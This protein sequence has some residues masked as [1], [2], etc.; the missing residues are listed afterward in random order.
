MK[1]LISIGICAALL[2][3]GENPFTPS[4]DDP[5]ADQHC[6]I[7]WPRNKLR[8]VAIDNYNSSLW[9]AIRDTTQFSKEKIKELTEA[10]DLLLLRDETLTKIDLYASCRTAY[11]EFAQARK[12]QP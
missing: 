10:R 3:C 8:L 7:S 4:I 12:G 9:I 5:Y 2:A 6:Q 1:T 11:Q